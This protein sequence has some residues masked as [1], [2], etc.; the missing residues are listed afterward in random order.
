VSGWVGVWVGG[1][2]SVAGRGGRADRW[3]CLSSRPPPSFASRVG[4]GRG[5]VPVTSLPG[6]FCCPT[7]RPP[8]PLNALP[9]AGGGGAEAEAAAAAT[10]GAGAATAA[11]GPRGAGQ[12]GSGG[13]TRELSPPPAQARFG[14]R[15]DWLWASGVH[16]NSIAPHTFYS[17]LRRVLQ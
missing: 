9:V 14:Q 4:V 6:R 5:W 17:P 3:R 13:G 2:V 1:C 16:P 10:A 12:W 15:K 11:P 7:A 8:P